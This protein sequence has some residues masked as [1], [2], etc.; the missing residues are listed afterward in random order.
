MT[1]RP[2]WTKDY[3]AIDGIQTFDEVDPDTACWKS[4]AKASIRPDLVKILNLSEKEF[5]YWYEP[6][7]SA[8]EAL[9]VNFEIFATIPNLSYGTGEF[10]MDA[11]TS[12]NDILSNLR[13][14]RNYLTKIYIA[15]IGH[16]RK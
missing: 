1:P 12:V 7:V 2:E 14:S 15:W 16:N 8:V 9:L 4:R 11:S 5:Q 3:P 6:K 10:G 13:K